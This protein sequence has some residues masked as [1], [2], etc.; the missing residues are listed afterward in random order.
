MRPVAA[1]CSS[2]RSWLAGQQILVQ[3]IMVSFRSLLKFPKLSGSSSSATLCGVSCCRLLR[4]PKPCSKWVRCLQFPSSNSTTP[5][6]LQNAHGTLLE[7]AQSPMRSC[8]RLLRLPNFGGKPN[9]LWHPVRSSS[10]R[11]QRLPKDFVNKAN[12]SQW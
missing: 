6:R 4:L 8:R 12:C 10:S 9:R 11:P 2:N 7:L 1:G 5:F 3:L